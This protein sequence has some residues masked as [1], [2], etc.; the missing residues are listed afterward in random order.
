MRRSVKEGL[1]FHFSGPKN[2][3]VFHCRRGH[4]ESDAF[5]TV[6]IYSHEL[7]YDEK[8]GVAHLEGSGEVGTV[9]RALRL[10]RKGYVE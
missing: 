1:L 5:V 10:L 7:P 8:L 2:M 3:D 4:I 9:H 6:E